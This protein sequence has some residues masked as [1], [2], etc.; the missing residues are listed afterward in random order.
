MTIDQ[1]EEKV[2]AVIARMLVVDISEVVP[3]ASLDDLGADSL[4]IVEIILELEEAFDIYEISDEEVG[5]INTVR[6][7]IECITKRRQGNGG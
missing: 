2:K 7:F 6:D 5:K 4:D 3:G 1:I